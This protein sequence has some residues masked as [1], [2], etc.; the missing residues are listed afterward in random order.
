MVS[1]TQAWESRDCMIG[2]PLPQTRHLTL[3]KSIT[4]LKPSLRLAFKS[5]AWA[6]TILRFLHIAWSCSDQFLLSKSL[7][8]RRKVRHVHRW[9][10][11]QANAQSGLNEVE[12][13]TWRKWLQG[14]MKFSYGGIYGIG[15]WVMVQLLQNCWK[16]TERRKTLTRQQSGVEMHSIFRSGERTNC[17]GEKWSTG[18]VLVRM[19]GQKV[20]LCVDSLLSN[21]TFRR[22]W[23]ALFVADPTER[24][25]FYHLWTI[26]LLDG[27]YFKWNNAYHI[28]SAIK[29]FLNRK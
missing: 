2:L 9:F 28:I 19:P 17:I 3:E 14:S 15:L 1:R 11:Y 7:L 4:W 5:C 27:Q 10:Y 21:S 26:K 18:N 20:K 24:Y 8:S 25:Y 23:N 13:Y 16:G 6:H 22:A 12:W 29:V